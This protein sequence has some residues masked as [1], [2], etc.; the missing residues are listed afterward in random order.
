MSISDDAAATT[1]LI[2]TGAAAKTVTLGSSNTTSTTTIVAGSGGINI[3]GVTLINDS[4]NS[5]T[6]I[7]T[8]TSTGTVTIGN[9]LAG[10]I[11]VDTG[12]GI[13]LDGV[14]ASNFTVT[15]AA[16]LTIASTAGSVIVSSGEA[17]ADAI[18]LTASDAAGGIT[19]A[20]GTGH[21]N[22]TGNL[23]FTTAGN[24][25][26]SASVATDG[27]AGANSFGSATLAAGTI[28]INTTAVT[29][30]SL[31][32]LSRMSPGATGAND[33]GILSVG[34][35]TAGASFVINALTVTDS[36]TVQTD[37]ASVVAWMIVN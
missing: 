3:D 16:D 6:S 1:L 2:G 32:Y 34:T 20:V 29:A 33:L 9:A 15:G 13:S 5:N 27:T 28:T 35:V 31:I 37:D 26:L 21:F 4:V 19:A 30:S 23:N 25:I 24:K 22:I 8:G 7:N 10:A 18:Q 36:T 14:T 17:V 12:A 11:N